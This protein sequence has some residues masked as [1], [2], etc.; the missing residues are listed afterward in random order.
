MADIVA[1][2]VKEKE[3]EGTMVEIRIRLSI[4]FVQH[5]HCQETKYLH[6]KI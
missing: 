5:I 3:D 4:L 1:G 6:L 2:N